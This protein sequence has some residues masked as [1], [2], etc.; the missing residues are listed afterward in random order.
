M[1]FLTTTTKT[2]TTAATPATSAATRT[3]HRVFLMS[4]PDH[5]PCRRKLRVE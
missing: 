4:H 3:S 1:P 5:A 2:T